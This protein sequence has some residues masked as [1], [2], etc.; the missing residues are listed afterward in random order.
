V[1]GARRDGQVGRV[2][3]VK[4]SVPNILTILEHDGELARRHMRGTRFTIL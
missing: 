2:A 1:A 3:V 4:L